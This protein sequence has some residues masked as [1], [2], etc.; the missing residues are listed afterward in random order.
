MF[1][2]ADVISLVLYCAQQLGVTLGVGAQTI[3]LVAYLSAMRDGVV[4][5]Q[6]AQFARAVRRVLN[7]GLVLIILSGVVITVM[8]VI[9]HTVVPGTNQPVVL[10][11]A[12]LFK[13]F[14]VIAVLA[15]TLLKNFPQ[16]IM[17]GLAGGSWYALFVV[18]IL[19]PVASWSTLLTFYAVWMIGF[20]LCWMALT[21]FTKGK[22]RRSATEVG[23]P[24]KASGKAVPP[25]VKPAPVFP[26]AP[27]P[28]PPPPKP[29]PPSIAP[30]PAPVPKPVPPPPLPAPK[31]L[32]PPAVTVPA[33]QQAHILQ[34]LPQPDVAKKQE[35]AVVKE[36]QNPWLPAIQIMPKTQS[37]ADKQNPK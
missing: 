33:P 16:N 21:Y 1:L 34:T 19:A 5:N 29:T 3:M 11:T 9:A 22:S 27:K 15:F 28:A 17:Q 13:W 14:L 32:A 24:T 30:P 18:H 2:S 36:D 37:D 8:H 10:T 26:F 12:Y 20:F 31:P 25:I 35:F 4:D 7:T 23:T 6:E